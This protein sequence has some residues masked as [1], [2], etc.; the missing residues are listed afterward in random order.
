VDP[1]T[2][3]ILGGAARSATKWW[4]KR[5]AV[6]NSAEGL[7]E[8]ACRQGE[9]EQ[10]RILIGEQ[11]DLNCQISGRTS[12]TS[13]TRKGHAAIVNL[14]LNSGAHVN[15]KDADEKSPLIH[16][17]ENGRSEIASL[18][19]SRGAKLE[20]RD[21]NGMTSFSHAVHS[22]YVNLALLLAMTH[23]ADV[24]SKDNAGRTPLMYACDQANKEMVEA[25]LNISASVN[26]CDK[27]GK[28]PVII[29]VSAGWFEHPE[30]V[31]LLLDRGADI[32]IQDKT[33]NTPL[34]L[35][36]SSKRHKIHELLLQHE[37]NRRQN[38]QAAGGETR[39]T[40]R[41]HNLSILE[42]SPNATPEDI[43]RRYRELVKKAH[44]DNGGDPHYFRV[45]QRAYEALMEERASSPEKATQKE[46]SSTNQSKAN[47]C[48]GESVTK[49]RQK[50]SAKELTAD[51]KAGLT[52]FQLMNK[53]GIFENSL[54]AAF[55]KLLE[56]GWLEQSDID[57][58]RSP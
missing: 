57:N 25:L 45:I 14:L 1:F 8:K 11:P 47:N 51:I 16:A 26:I 23:N 55:R 10:A 48:T 46:T 41:A 17:C 40:L 38:N 19:L 27:E 20:D 18:L 2:L 9:L 39:E 56:L 31:Q 4:N 37:L 21:K 49:N 29:A 52:D 36:N 13:A 33:G 35:A 28:T 43:N 53:Y 15:S 24:D 7:L 12:L 32:E 22:G 54:N 42:L 6:Q 58:R 5:Q 44:P 34:T 30:I 3:L 50:I